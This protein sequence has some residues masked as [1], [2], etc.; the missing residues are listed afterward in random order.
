MGLECNGNPDTSGLKQ[1][2]PRET[3]MYFLF[4]WGGNPATRGRNVV[5]MPQVYPPPEGSPA[6]VS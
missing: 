2:L 6:G 1:S 4:N 5:E 3:Y